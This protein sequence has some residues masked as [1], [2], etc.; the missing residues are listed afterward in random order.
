MIEMNW[1]KYEKSWSMYLIRD[2]YRKGYRLFFN[3]DW[4]IWF[5]KR[6][7]IFQYLILIIRLQKKYFTVNIFIET[8]INK[9]WE[10]NVMENFSSEL[11]IH[12]RKK[13]QL[14]EFILFHSN[15]I[16]LNL[17]LIAMNISIL[18]RISFHLDTI[19][20]RGRNNW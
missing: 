6:L 10:N 15:I 4:D 2:N 3:F 19:D 12:F 20:Q 11:S 1:M 18:F 7:F 14:L 13:E 17:F 16:D 8:G 9:K 5:M